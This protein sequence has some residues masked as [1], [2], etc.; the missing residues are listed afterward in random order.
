MKY[1]YDFNQLAKMTE[2]FINSKDRPVL[3]FNLRLWMFNELVNCN[4]LTLSD[5]YDKYILLQELYD[6][7]CADALRNYCLSTYNNPFE[8][9]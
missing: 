2:Y 9:V 1:K 5:S 4:P 7:L 6:S 3:P 8:E